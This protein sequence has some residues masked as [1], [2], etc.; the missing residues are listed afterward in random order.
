MS[1][2]LLFVALLGAV[3]C[4]NY[5]QLQDAE[6]LPAGQ[7]RFGVGASF[8]N[9]K[10]KLGTNQDGTPHE[11]TVSVPAVVVTARRGLTDDLEVQA[12]AWLPLGARAGVKYRLLGEAGKTGLHVSLGAHVGYLKLSA[13]SDNTDSSVTFIDAYVPLYVG[14]RLS[15]SFEV[16][17]APQY[18]L[19]SAFGASSD[20]STTSN[21]AQ[22]G[23]VI[24]TTVGIAIGSRSKFFLE[25]GGFYDTFYSTPIVNGAIG[26]AF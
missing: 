18:I 19:R 3:G 20:G 7:Q 11:D 25:G 23:H 10:L 4:A 2:S 21:G 5:S 8:S 22:F 26:L 9:Y 1:R 13:S 17:S 6:T 24:G 16:Y 14:Y 12:A 15:E